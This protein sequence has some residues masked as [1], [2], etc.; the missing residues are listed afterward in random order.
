[1]A[2]A[3]MQL[4]PAVA[5]AR[6]VLAS[7]RK[8]L[9]AMANMKQFAVGRSTTNS[10]ATTRCCFTAPKMRLDSATGWPENTSLP[11]G[12][13]APGVTFSGRWRST[14]SRR[15]SRP[16]ARC[17]KPIRRR[18]W[19]FGAIRPIALRNMQS[20]KLPSCAGIRR[21]VSSPTILWVSS[22]ISI[23]TN[24]ANAWISAAGIRIHSEK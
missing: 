15:S 10:A 23:T 5:G 9:S 7:P 22:T 4:R 19:I 12:S 11:S 6:K 2:R 14:V 1:M 21:G 3:V 16:A 13:T 20:C 24:S 8:W 17:R 18:G